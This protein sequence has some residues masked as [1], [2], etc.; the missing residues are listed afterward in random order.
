[1]ILIYCKEIFDKL[2]ITRKN[3]LFFWINSL[4][5]TTFF[6]VLTLILIGIIVSFSLS[7]AASEKVGLKGVTFFSKH[8]VF[9]GV[10]VIMIIAI[11]MQSTST[12]KWIC[13]I[14]IIGVLCA[15]IMTLFGGEIKGS[16]RWINFGGFS[17]QPSE[18]LKPL[19]IYIFS[20]IFANLEGL[21]LKQESLKVFHILLFGLHFIIN[22]LLFLQP[23]F[24]MILTF[25]LLFLALFY[26]NL[27]SIKSFFLGGLLL[28][29]C[30]AFIG[31]FLEHVKFRI[32]TFFFGLENYQSKLAF[33][34]I[35][36]GGF[37]GSGFAESKLKFTLPEA[38]NDF[39]FAILIEEFGFIFVAILGLVFLLLVFSNFVYIFDFKEKLTKMFA[40]INYTSETTDESTII[41]IIKKNYKQ[42]NAKK[43]LNIYIDFLFT[44]NFIFLTSVLLIF[45]F[46]LNASVSLNLAPT[47]GIA[48]PF[49]SYG[50]SSLVSHG[51]LIGLL[52]AFNRKRYFFLI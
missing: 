44:R 16:R 51:I 40:K 41:S 30:A 10:A 18:F 49:I 6:T 50:G 47:K 29:F 32:K 38:H 52:L 14:G 4:H 45:E 20:L 7:Y 8:L 42:Q 9:T 25:N 2:M 5:K 22:L 37:F 46:F 24:G 12:L 15:I 36:N 3:P 21:K 39:I 34:A 33:E 19:Y 28:G 26:I 27:N 35:Q 43:Y 17:I 11:S 23:D 1:M 31:F 48:M 13:F